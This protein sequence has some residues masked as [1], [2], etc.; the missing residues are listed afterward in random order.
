M[1]G[2]QN[3][4]KLHPGQKVMLK[5]PKATFKRLFATIFKGR[6]LTFVLVTLCII[7]SALSSTFVATLL[8]TLI[9]DYI[10]PLIGQTNPD[11][12]PLLHAMVGWALILGVGIL[13][14]Y[15]MS[16]LMVSVGQN[17]M[18]NTRK[19]VFKKLQSLPLSY[20]DSHPHGQIMSV[21]TN[22]TDAMNQMI[23]QSLV[24]LLSSFFTIAFVL[25]AMFK[26]SWLLTLIV[27]FSLIFYA[28][29]VSAV[30][31]KSRAN[32]T[33]QQA[34]VAK[35][36]SNI[37]E[38]ISGVKVVKVFNHEAV[39]EEEFEKINEDLNKTMGKANGYANMMGPLV[40][41]MGNLQYVVL[42]LIGALIAMDSKF[43]YTIGA[44]AAFLQLARSFSNPIGQI[45][46]QVSSVLMAAAGAERVFALLDEESE[47]DDGYVTL[48]NAKQCDGKL[49]E[50]DE[51]TN[52]WAWKHNHHDG[53]VTY[54]PVEGDIQFENVDFGYVPDKIV[55]KDI[56][57]Y[58]HPSQK[59]AFVGSTGAG[60]TTITNLLNRF[61]EIQNGKIRFDGINIQKIKKA[62]LRRALGIIL[63]DTHLFTGTIMD[64]LRYGRMDATDEEVIEAAKLAGAHSFISMMKD[65]YN[66]MVT[67]DGE[68]LSGGQRQLLAIARAAVADPPVLIMDEATSSID[69]NTEEI[70]QRG[71]RH[72][73]EGRT[74]FVIAHR[75]STVKN[76]D[77][78]MVLDH[79]KIIERGSHEE[80]LKEKGTYYKLYTGAF[81][82]E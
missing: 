45:A 9:D 10:T 77:C 67:N 55:L 20:F 65:G 4:R 73:M 57:L 21:I 6:K 50:C 76:C 68:G 1:R 49:V 12:S 11:F 61:Y 33:L 64:N 18:D 34:N 2:P 15:F 56:S 69:T 44:L 13:A 25:V 60:K 74:V 59:L 80:L 72:L 23:S 53:T 28:I 54:V 5:N 66:T 27:L 14:T 82:L 71:I 37:E 81:E 46:Q 16:R 43:G 62:D 7:I 47:V 3:G 63:Q 30:G 31:K 58:A 8:E 22:D 35:V 70:V 41:N 17:Y 19:E 78:I 52:V 39:A 24:S 26:N 29:S 51:K 42:V 38:L 36:N 32:F 40:N 75:L 79:G 48:V